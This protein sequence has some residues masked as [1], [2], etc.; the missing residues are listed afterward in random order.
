[1][2]SSPTRRQ[3]DWHVIMSEGENPAPRLASSPVLPAEL[4]A[5][6]SQA[7]SEV[8]FASVDRL[9]HAAVEAAR[10]S[11]GLERA[12]IFLH[13][14]KNRRM[15]GSWGTDGAGNTVDEHGLTYDCGPTDQEI[16]ARARE[17]FPWSV[18]Q[19]APLTE[20]THD[21]TRV[22][23]HG[24]VAC[25]VIDGAQAPLAV[26][27]NDTA[28]SGAPLDEAKQ[29]R[30]AMLCAELKKALWRCRSVLVP[31]AAD[32][33]IVRHVASLLAKDPTLS[34][35][36]I[37]R[38]LRVSPGELARRF[39][40]GAGCSIV[41]Y[42]NELRLSG[43]LRNLNLHPSN[44]LEAALD[45]G[46]GSYAQF[47]RVFRARLGRTPRQYLLEHGHDAGQLPESQR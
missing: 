22:L 34:C 47:C 17:G 24:W 37:A 6:A 40:D 30:A 4:A 20:H 10:Y 32:D 42:R 3:I 25:T 43:F 23:R 35:A 14:A 16:F 26:L 28:I 31:A 39:K 7:M 5:L 21:Q 18:Y 9:L 41:D 1:M 44:L 11:I 12:A 29:W 38:E 27:F 13:D 46:F 8:T 19:D 45:C 15:I 33:P 2:T 36:A